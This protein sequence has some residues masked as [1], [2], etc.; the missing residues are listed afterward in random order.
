MTR[1][2]RNLKPDEG[3]FHVMCR[4]NNGNQIFMDLPDYEIFLVLVRKYT[5]KLCV[6]LH[7][8]VLMNNHYHMMVSTNGETLPKLMQCLNHGY[9]MKHRK[10]YS[11][12]G[13]LWQGRYKC[14]QIT[15]ESQLLTCGAYIELNPVRAG[16]VANPE[17][18]RWSSYRHFVL[19]QNDLLIDELPEYVQLSTDI[20]ERRAIY[21]AM[22]KMW[23][24][25]E[26]VAVP[27]KGLGDRHFWGRG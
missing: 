18:Y 26:I 4:G 25:A 24:Y 9:S 20:N 10:K 21:A 2:A 13:P 14:V 15:D 12:E 1:H 17:D 27:N 3:I 22:V 8:Y 16:L 6:H 23:H 7:H 11:R 5:E 19:G